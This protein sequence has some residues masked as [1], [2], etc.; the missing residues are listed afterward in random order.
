MSERTGAERYLA[1]RMKD[2]EY[3]VEYWKAVL[4]EMPTEAL[5]KEAAR[6]VEPELPRLAK[7]LRIAA[8]VV[9]EPPQ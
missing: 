8:G 4:E 3:R 7:D 9:L 1:E 6:R 5:L 2:A